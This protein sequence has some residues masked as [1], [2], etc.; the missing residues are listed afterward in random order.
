MKYAI[1]MLKTLNVKQ[2]KTEDEWRTAVDTLESNGT[3]YTPLKYNP[4]VEHYVIQK[5]VKV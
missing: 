5:V 1:V 4:M 2:F 3:P